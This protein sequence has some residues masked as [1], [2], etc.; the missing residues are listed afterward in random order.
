MALLTKS[1]TNNGPPP[2]P[3]APQLPQL[4]AQEA[5]LSLRGAAIAQEIERLEHD[6]KEAHAF[7]ADMA[8]RTKVAEKLTEDLRAELNHVRNDR[9]HY[10]DRFKTV[11][12]KFDAVRL[13]IA[14]VMKEEPEAERAA[15]PAPSMAQAPQLQALA[16]ELSPPAPAEQKE[17]AT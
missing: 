8:S 1:K 11:K 13:I 7:A 15:L 10:H 4:R 3:P 6:L 16:D 2:I 17:P 12:A 14:D 5:A 9:D